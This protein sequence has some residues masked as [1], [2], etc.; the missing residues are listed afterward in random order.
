LTGQ[1]LSEKTFKF[2]GMSK[3][4]R[5]KIIYSGRVQGV[6]FRW[7]V[8][9]LVKDFKVTGFV[10][11]LD[12]GTVETLLEGGFDEIEKATKTIEF[13]LKDYWTSKNV[14]HRPGKPHYAA[15]SIIY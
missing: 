8:V 3:E 12:N 7:S 5:R 1:I 10:R 13:R 4:F 9:R 6:G 11:N 15:F 14:E 2:Q